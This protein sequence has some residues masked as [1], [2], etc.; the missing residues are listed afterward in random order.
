MRQRKSERL[1]E[2]VREE[3]DGILHTQIA[4]PRLG[5]VTITRVKV[6]SDGTHASIFYSTFGSDDQRTQSREA[7]ESS[8]GH[9]R[10]LLAARL[11]VRAVPELHFIHDTS[12]E[13]GEEVLRLI[14][15]IETK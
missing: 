4:D 2:A 8:R 14:R 10:K 1:T 11:R 13:K 3:V 12:V 7:M 15:E 6:S 5:F 9:V